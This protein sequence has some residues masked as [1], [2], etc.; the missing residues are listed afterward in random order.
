[1]SITAS[2]KK[3]ASKRTVYIS[4]WFGN[5]LISTT[6]NTQENVAFAK[7]QSR[8]SRENTERQPEASATRDPAQFEKRGVMAK[9]TSGGRSI[10]YSLAIF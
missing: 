10:S 1:M 3:Q 4:G 8:W 5:S 9:N 7:H 2:F 6:I